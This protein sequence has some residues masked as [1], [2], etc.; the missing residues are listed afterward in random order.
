MIDFFFDM[1]CRIGSHLLH[2]LK[3]HENAE[4]AGLQNGKFEFNQGTLVVCAT[5]TMNILLFWVLLSL[6]MCVPTSTNEMSEMSERLVLE[7]HIPYSCQHHGFVCEMLGY[8]PAL[9]NVF[10]PDNI[11]VTGLGTCSDNIL[12]Q[13]APDERIA[14]E[15]SLLVSKKATGAQRKRLVDMCVCCRSM[16]T[17][18]HITF[19]HMLKR[20]GESIC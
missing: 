10:G 20:Q 7:W 14:L 2:V 8:L 15:T 11:E 16:F 4:E 17:Y 1:M 3:E 13:F 19:S 18:I 5:K 6:L 12:E 9:Q